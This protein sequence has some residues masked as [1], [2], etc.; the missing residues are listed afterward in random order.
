MNILSNLSKGKSRD[1]DTV[2]YAVKEF[3][4]KVPCRHAACRFINE[5]GI[6]GNE[7]RGRAC[8]GA[9]EYPRF[10]FTANQHGR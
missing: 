10:F 9:L 3:L 2:E 4:A 7:F 8:Q 1:K 6:D 5:H